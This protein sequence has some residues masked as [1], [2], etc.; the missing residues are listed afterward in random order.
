[1][2]IERGEFE[3]STDGGAGAAGIDG[4][5]G[6]HLNP[7]RSGVARF[8]Q[9]LAQRLGVPVVG[10]FSDEVSGLRRPLF[11][12]KAAELTP[13]EIHVLE[14]MLEGMKGRRA[15]QVFLHDYA[16][17]AIEQRMV[18]EAELVWCGNLEVQEHIS[19][20]TDRLGQAWAPGLILDTRRFE[21]AELSVFSF[22]MAHKVR[23]DMF[24]R[25]RAL[26][27][28]SGRSYVLYMSNAD[29]ETASAEDAQLV[30]EQM[31]RVFPRGL[32]FMGNL[33][34]VAVYNHLLSCTFFAAFF[35][36]GVRANNTS[37]ASAM[38]HGAVVI[39]NLDEHS[40]RHLVHMDNVV[41]INRCEE[42][43]ADP[44]VLKR[45]S[46]RAMETAQARSWDELV[47]V[48]SSGTAPDRERKTL[49]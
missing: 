23:A 30:F 48:L 36:K 13:H 49:A 41:D 24:E 27:D 25:L 9:I 6:H 32:Y 10:L 45:L 34:D 42:L 5:V 29:H 7:Y 1:V 43:P 4:V 44:L 21:P 26:L 17:L 46:I 16:G 3:V 19:G 11:S 40:P 38:E 12:F 8:N 33:S 31:R 15:H 35:K 47:K 37:I 39:T 18:C 2:T 22:G 14:S 28:A 20:L